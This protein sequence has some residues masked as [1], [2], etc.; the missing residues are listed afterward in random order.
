MTMTAAVE[1]IANEPKANEP[2]IVKLLKMMITM[3]ILTVRGG[4]LSVRFWSNLQH[5][6]VDSTTPV[7]F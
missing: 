5:F 2:L 6:R 7:T 3:M 4:S 1:D